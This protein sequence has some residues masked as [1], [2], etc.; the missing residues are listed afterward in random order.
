MKKKIVKL[1]CDAL[2]SGEY[3]QGKCVLKDSE[4]NL[5][6]SI[7]VLND[8]YEKAHPRSKCTITLCG[9]LYFDS[10]SENYEKFLNWCGAEGQF[11]YRNENNIRAF[12]GDMDDQGKSFEEI[13]KFIEENHKI[14]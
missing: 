5:F 8:L 14:F 13:A 10:S 2:R 4:K 11:F 6:C 1:W 7:G 12:L 3:K 9:E